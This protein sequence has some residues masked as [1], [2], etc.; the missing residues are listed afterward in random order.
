MERQSAV[1]QLNR[2]E[3]SAGNGRV[4]YRARIAFP[5]IIVLLF[6]Q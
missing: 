3:R 5:Q 2:R 1:I 6:G 4:K